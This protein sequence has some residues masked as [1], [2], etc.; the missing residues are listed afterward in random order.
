VDLS[1]SE[2][3]FYKAFDM[4]REDPAVKRQRDRL[5]AKEDALRERLYAEGVW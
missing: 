2:I 4:V 3:D 1:S 5:R